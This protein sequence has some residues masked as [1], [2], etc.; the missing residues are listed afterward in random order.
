MLAGCGHWAPRYTCRPTGS[1]PPQSEVSILERRNQGSVE[2]PSHTAS[3]WQTQD[4]SPVRPRPQRQFF[5][6]HRGDPR[7]K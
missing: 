4:G 7:R 1:G 6:L 5:E 2:S 3:E